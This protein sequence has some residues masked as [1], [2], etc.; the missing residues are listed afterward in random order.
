MEMLKAFLFG[1]AWRAVLYTSLVS[2]GIIAWKVGMLAA[3]VAA[4]QGIM[5]P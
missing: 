3:G 2:I 5:L 1:W 4:G